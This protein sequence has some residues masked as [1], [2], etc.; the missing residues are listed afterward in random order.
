[1]RTGRSGVPKLPP[2]RK[3]EKP[4]QPGTPKK[5]TVEVGP[6]VCYGT[7]KR[8]IARYERDLKLMVDAAVRAVFDVG[9]HS[10]TVRSRTEEA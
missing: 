8:D 7:G 4:F 1:M 10:K 5:I 6:I 2:H 9:P 3:G